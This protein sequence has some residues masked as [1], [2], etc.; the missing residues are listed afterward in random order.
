MITRFGL[1]KDG[2]WP[3]GRPETMSPVTGRGTKRQ[4]KAVQLSV[5]T[6]ARLVSAAAKTIM[7]YEY[8]SPFWTQLFWG[9][10][11]TTLETLKHCDPPPRSGSQFDL[12]GCENFVGEWE[13]FLFNAFVNLLL[14]QCRDSRMGVIWEDL[15]ALITVG[16]V[17]DSSKSVYLIQRSSDMRIAGLW[18]KCRDLI[19]E[20]K[21]FVKTKP[22][23]KVACRMSGIEWWVVYFR[24]LLFE[25]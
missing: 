20:G 5:I 3:D 22:R 10:W 17:Q 12:A 9:R 14:S 15:G 11:S 19:G 23:F 7:F 16:H 1:R 8:F 6:V 18:I 24:K 21:M 13:E 25:S 2:H 4:L